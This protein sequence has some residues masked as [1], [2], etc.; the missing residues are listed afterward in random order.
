[1]GFDLCNCTLKIPKSIWDSNS[2][3]GSSLG[4]VKVHSLTLFALSKACDVTPGL[5]SWH[6]TLQAL[7]LVVSPRLWSRHHIPLSGSCG[8]ASPFEFGGGEI[9]GLFCPSPPPTITLVDLCCVTVDIC[10][11]SG[12][13]ITTCIWV[14]GTDGHTPFDIRYVITF[15]M[16]ISKVVIMFVPIDII[17]VPSGKTYMGLPTPI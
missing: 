14:V 3:N 9:S 16:G 6:K 17:D 8:I 10:A 11:L 5:P 13:G 1:M 7:A 12:I 2:Y 4:N 15:H